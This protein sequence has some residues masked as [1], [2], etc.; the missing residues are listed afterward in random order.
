MDAST[1]IVVGDNISGLGPN[2]DSVHFP[3]LRSL[4]K[5][6]G[7]YRRIEVKGIGAA[8]GTKA[9]SPN[10][11]RVADE[12]RD[13]YWL[14]VV[15]HCDTRPRLDEPIKD[16]TRFPWH[17]VKKVEHYRL[18]VNAFSQPVEFREQPSQ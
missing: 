17:E 4:H 13:I 1:S 10:E 7:E 12:R 2:L 18:D 9:L 3:D 5:T 11:K 8:T 14:Y 16:P 15:T 6:T